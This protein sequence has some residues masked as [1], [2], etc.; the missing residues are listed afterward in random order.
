MSV[1]K[2]GHK[3]ELS[4]SYLVTQ[5]KLTGFSVKMGNHW[6]KPFYKNSLRIW[7]SNQELILPNFVSS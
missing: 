3:G 5:E 1:K 4:G 2:I 6:T 7:E